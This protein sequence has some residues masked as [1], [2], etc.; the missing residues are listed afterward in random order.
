MT[1]LH[2]TWH[3]FHL[4]LSPDGYLTVNDV[5]RAHISAIE[6]SAECRQEDSEADIRDTI[7]YFLFSGIQ[8]TITVNVYKWESFGGFKHITINVENDV[9]DIFTLDIP[10]YDQ[11]Q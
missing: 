9:Y 3:G 2:A 6:R 11:A 7:V 10:M 8:F 1:D 5:Y 4:R